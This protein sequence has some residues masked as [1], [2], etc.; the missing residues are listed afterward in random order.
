M[1]MVFI[2]GAVRENYE[3]FCF[4]IISVMSQFLES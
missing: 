2:Q 1:N 4:M 3:M